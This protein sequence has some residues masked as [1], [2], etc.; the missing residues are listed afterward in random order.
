MDVS[1]SLDPSVETLTYAATSPTDQ[2]VY[3][4]L[5]DRPKES[6]SS[7]IESSLAIHP[8]HAKRLLR[9]LTSPTITQT[10]EY[11]HI[12]IPTP[13]PNKLTG[14]TSRAELTI[15]LRPDH[16]ITAHQGEVRFVT[17]LFR[18]SQADSELWTRLAE[19]GASAILWSIIDRL[20]VTIQALA[21][22][23]AH[24]CQSIEETTIARLLAGVR[25][26]LVSPRVEAEASLLRR[27]NRALIDIASAQRRIVR[28]LLARQSEN[29]SDD[30]RFINTSIEARETADRFSQAEKALHDASAALECFE[31]AQ[32]NGQRRETRDLLRVVAILNLIVLPALI[33][34][35]L[36]GLSISDLPL[37]GEPLAFEIILLVIT[38]L[39]LGVLALARR[40]GWLN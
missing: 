24:E 18:D 13:I 14:Q 23:H 29:P 10:P 19:N 12:V 40:Q 32:A 34:T 31:L 21:D 17:R 27:E 9:R 38:L 25:G 6:D 22:S 4:S 30:R 28:G 1:P 3:W 5:I 11:L 7:E 20:G 16:L 36:F 39:V 8:A 35:T 2:P 26:E 15:F 37:A 33:V